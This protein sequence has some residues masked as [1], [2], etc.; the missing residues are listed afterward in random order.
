M[1]TQAQ[2]VAAARARAASG[3]ILDYELS[4]NGQESLMAPTHY[5]V[6]IRTQM[7]TVDIQVV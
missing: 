1:A 3:A 6:L 5:P 7:M 4:D 2:K